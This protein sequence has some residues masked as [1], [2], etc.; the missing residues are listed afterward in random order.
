[1]KEMQIFLPSSLLTSECDLV[2]DDI[3]NLRI[4]LCSLDA[5]VVLK[6]MKEFRPVYCQV[7]HLVNMDDILPKR[8]CDDLV[9]STNSGL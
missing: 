2:E 7:H 1:M 8:L 4:N 6:E 5:T 3:R 9:L